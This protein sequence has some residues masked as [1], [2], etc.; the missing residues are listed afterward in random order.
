M[1]KQF[2]KVAG[3]VLVF[4]VTIV[5]GGVASAQKTDGKNRPTTTND[6]KYRPRPKA[7]SVAGVAVTNRRPYAVAKDF[8]FAIDDAGSLDSDDSARGYTI[9]DL[10]YL[11]D[12]LDGQAEAATLQALLKD[13]IHGNKNAK[14]TV[15]QISA[16]SEGFFKRLTNEQKWYYCV[17]E[18]QANLMIAAWSNDDATIKA[19]L[20]DMQALAQL[21]PKGT[22]LSLVDAVSGLTKYMAKATF[23]KD[24]FTAIVN[25]AKVITTEVSA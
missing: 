10:V 8:A 23:T 18:T 13:V 11:I 20:K 1:K 9:V 17:G 24:D 7:M 3:L 14:A 6:I 4:M 22:S 15:D 16:V 2:N 19:R 21:A 5:L 12:D 25:D